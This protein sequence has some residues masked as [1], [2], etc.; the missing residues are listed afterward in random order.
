MAS[1][2]SDD[3]WL[4]LDFRYRGQRCR[5]YPNLRDSRDAWVE[6]NRTSNAG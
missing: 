3:G 6:A 1:V 5:E 2:R 4:F